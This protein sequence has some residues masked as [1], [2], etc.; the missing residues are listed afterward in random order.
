MENG[1]GTGR[2]KRWQR[3]REERQLCDVAVGQGT[4]YW[5]AL[6]Y[7]LS[8]Q[9]SA[10]VLL[11]ITSGASPA[12]HWGA[13]VVHA[14]HGRRRHDGGVSRAAHSPRSRRSPYRR[15]VHTP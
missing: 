15:A 10:P 7:V 4:S 5:R 3:V 2:G 12:S 13:S 9:P 6:S 14:R 11:I 8:A 1:I